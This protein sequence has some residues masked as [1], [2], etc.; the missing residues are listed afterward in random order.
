MRGVAWA[1]GDAGGAWAVGA[2]C[3]VGRACAHGVAQDARRWGAAQDARRRDVSESLTSS[4]R[5]E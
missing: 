2:W 4:A 5:S 3:D 1:V